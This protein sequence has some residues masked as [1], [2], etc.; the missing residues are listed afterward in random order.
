LIDKDAV[1][2]AAEMLDN[3]PIGLLF[4]CLSVDFFLLADKESLLPDVS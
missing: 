1:L 3:R 2:F 4:A